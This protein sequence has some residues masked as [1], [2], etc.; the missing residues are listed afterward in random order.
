MKTSHR[1]QLLLFF[2]T[3]GVVEL[4]LMKK[5]HI[6]EAVSDHV[7]DHDDHIYTSVVS[8]SHTSTSDHFGLAPR[9]IPSDVDSDSSN[10]SHPE[11]H[12]LG[13]APDEF[14][15][16]MNSETLSDSEDNQESVTGEVSLTRSGR[17]SKPPHRYTPS[18]AV[19]VAV[20]LVFILGTQS[21]LSHKAAI[22]HNPAII[23]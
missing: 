10:T 2:Q 4:H 3:E 18:K 22:Y 13:G 19:L 7:S 14:S 5:K 15:D 6:T 9:L 20:L 11:P 17:P 16:H 12:P 23:T 8:A 1:N 21:Y